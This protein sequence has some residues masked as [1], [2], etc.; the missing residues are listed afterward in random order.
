LPRDIEDW[1]AAGFIGGSPQQITDQISAF[2]ESG[3]ERFMLQHNDLDDLASLELMAEEVLP[4]FDSL[5]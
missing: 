3:I 5:K 4:H 2:A 1:Q